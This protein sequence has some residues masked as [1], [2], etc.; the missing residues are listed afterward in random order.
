MK[1]NKNLSKQKEEELTQTFS[2]IDKY[3]VERDNEM[4]V[5]S[6]RDFVSKFELEESVKEYVTIYTFL[7][8]LV[9]ER[10]FI[11]S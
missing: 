4:L 8:H 11:T 6:L 3:I 9:E 10:E 2:Q 1:R 5:K 7:L